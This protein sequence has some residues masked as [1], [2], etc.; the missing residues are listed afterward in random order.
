[1]LC[2]IS[3]RI[4]RLI[5]QLCKTVLRVF[6]GKVA[7]IGCSAVPLLRCSPPVVMLTGLRSFPP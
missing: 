5:A 7:T 1:M 2:P 3:V 6:N 4:T